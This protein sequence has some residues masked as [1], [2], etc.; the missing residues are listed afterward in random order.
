MKN[1]LIAL[2]VIALAA[3]GYYIY[4]NKSLGNV[5]VKRGVESMAQGDFSKMGKAPDFSVT[6]LDG[7][8]VTLA[9]L[10]GK[11]VVLN[12]WATWCP[13]C[14]EEIP[15]LIALHEKNK[16][17]GLVVLGVSMDEGGVAEVKEFVAKNK[18]TY[19]VAMAS[20]TIADDYGG[21][22]AIP[23]TF[24]INRDGAIIEKIVGDRSLEQF[25]KSVQPSL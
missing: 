11:V 3:G 16:A 12:F 2:A 18:M 20:S 10:K 4:R 15:A 5:G 24:I 1:I 9:D 25:E 17:R 13:P 21:V 8:T 19:P 14:R 7:K 6:D 23:T 22:R